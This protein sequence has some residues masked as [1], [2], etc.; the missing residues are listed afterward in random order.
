MHKLK[1]KSL[2]LALVAGFGAA[3]MASSASAVNV[4]ANGF[5]Q[6]LI[7]PYYSVRQGTDTYISLTN[8]SNDYKAIRVRFNE[9]KNGRPVLGFNLY[10]SPF[11][12]WTA[13]IVSTPI[14]AKLLTFDRSCTVPQIPSSGQSF[15]NYAYAGLTPGFAFDGET[16]G[17]DRTREGFVEII[18]M[19]VIIN[20]ADQNAI[21]Q[22]NGIPTNCGA[23]QSLRMDTNAGV[24]AAAPPRGGLTGTATLLNAST[25]TEFTYDATALDNFSRVNIWYEPGNPLPDLRSATPVSDV[26]FART[27]VRD[28]WTP[29]TA[30]AVTAVLMHNQVVSDYLL[31]TVTLSGTDYVITMPTKHYNVPVYNPTSLTIPPIKPPF[32]KRFWTGGACEP[33]SLSVRNREASGMSPLGSTLC[34]ESTVLT[35]N[36]SQVLGSRNAV[37]IP[38]IHVNGFAT[39][40]LN[41]LGHTLVNPISHRTYSGL[42]VVGF[43]VQDYIIGMPQFGGNFMH[44]YKTDIR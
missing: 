30:Q 17:L 10:L 11:D 37:N 44:K 40:S 29:G 6:V 18:E 26:Y 43:T 25:G 23:L 21:K 20:T 2:Y 15:V 19:G 34:W 16:Q 13:A 28:Y 14:G 41:G 42:P 1:M 27:N 3:G 7:Y 38:V 31:D 4:D 22:L 5:G 12:M 9:G 39:I 35:F 32:T 36:N 33:V 24:H 8:S